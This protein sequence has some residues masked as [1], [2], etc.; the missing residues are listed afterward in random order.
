MYG[1][2]FSVSKF[3]FEN[4]KI[5]LKD[6]RDGAFNTL[7]SRRNDYFS[8]D[9]YHILQHEKTINGSNMDKVG[10]GSVSYT[11]LTLP[12]KRIV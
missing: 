12:T 8:T 5:I 10:A 2:R 11:H 9:M 3:I 1:G 4:R 6:Y 7:A